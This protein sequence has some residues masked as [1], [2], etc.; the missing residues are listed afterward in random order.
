MGSAGCVAAA[1]AAAGL[2]EDTDRADKTREREND[3]NGAAAKATER[4]ADARVSETRGESRAPEQDSGSES[5][6][7][8]EAAVG[9]SVQ[10][11]AGDDGDVMGTKSDDK[12]SKKEG[13][14]DQDGSM[15]SIDGKGAHVVDAAAEQKGKNVEK[16]GTSKE[17][18]DGCDGAPDELQAD[19]D[20]APRPRENAWGKRRVYAGRWMTISVCVD[21]EAG[22]MSC[23]VD[24]ACHSEEADLDKRE[25]KLGHR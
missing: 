25:L 7:A 23:Y 11:I 10:A 14:E 17:G 3:K 12:T 6:S 13:N 24:G 16:A 19:R 18:S 9:A 22:K 21:A 4:S 8:A 20:A 15:Q 2:D 1:E 5:G